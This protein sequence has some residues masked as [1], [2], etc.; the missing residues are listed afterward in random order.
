MKTYVRVAESTKTKKK[1]AAL[2][3]PYAGDTREKLAFLRPVDFME[4]LGL[5]PQE[6]YDLPC[7]NYEI[8]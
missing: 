4:L 2:V 5:A 7:G 8:K 3:I 1:Y 6:F